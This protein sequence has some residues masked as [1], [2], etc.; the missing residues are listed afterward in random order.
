MYLQTKLCHYQQQVIQTNKTNASPSCHLSTLSPKIEVHLSKSKLLL[1]TKQVYIEKTMPTRV[2]Q[3][4]LN[5]ITE[6]LC[7]VDPKKPSNNILGREEEK[8]ELE[9]NRLLSISKVKNAVETTLTCSKCFHSK[10][11]NNLELFF[12]DIKNLIIPDDDEI[13][14]KV[15][16]YL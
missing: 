15:K 4:E 5:S 14:T 16:K 9:G 2:S 1:S 12:S 10:D 3:R 13:K 8:F 7:P 11:E 6:N